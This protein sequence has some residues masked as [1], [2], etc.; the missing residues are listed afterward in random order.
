MLGVIKEIPE[1]IKSWNENREQVYTAVASVAAALVTVAF[2]TGARP[3]ESLAVVA[4]GLG[5]SPVEE[6]LTSNAPPLLASRDEAVSDTVL[7]GV[8]LLLA[9]MIVVPLLRGRREGNEM[10]AY[11]LLPLIGAPSAA[12]IW[13]LLMI[14]GQYG[15]IAAPM[16]NWASTASTVGFRTLVGLGVAGVLYLIAKRHGRDGLVRFLLLPPAMV[17]YRVFVGMGFAVFAV[18]FAA[19]ALP[20]SVGAWFAGLESDRSRKIRV[21]I[22]QKHLDEPVAKGAAIVRLDQLG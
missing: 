14:A 7:V 16:R 10:F 22:E 13:V 20:L 15:D 11:E 18:V 3:S 8:L 2:L 6:W 12:T 19:I 4:G 5:L 9:R 1:T 21:E 17:V